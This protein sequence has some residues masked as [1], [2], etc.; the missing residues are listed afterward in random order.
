LTG[1]SAGLTRHSWTSV[2]LI[3]LAG[4]HPAFW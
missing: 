3:F 2:W 4:R 1:M